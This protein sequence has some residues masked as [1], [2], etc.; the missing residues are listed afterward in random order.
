MHL[1]SRPVQ[2]RGQQTEDIGCADI[3]GHHPGAA[4]H[5]TPCHAASHHLVTVTLGC[6][7]FHIRN[8]C[9]SRVSVIFHVRLRVHSSNLGHL[10]CGDKEPDTR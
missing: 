8:R 1:Q 5:I 7:N 10:L 4:D 9:G 6:A 3:P 2:H